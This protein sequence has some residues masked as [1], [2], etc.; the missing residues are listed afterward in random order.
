MQVESPESY[1]VALCAHC[2]M[3]GCSEAAV[4]VAELSATR[5]RLRDALRD[6]PSGSA[7][8]LWLGAIGPIASRVGRHGPAG[9][10]IEFLAPLDPAILGHFAA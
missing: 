6:A 10:E 1:D 4:L 8:S 5:C 9:Q 3:E 7:L 2:Q